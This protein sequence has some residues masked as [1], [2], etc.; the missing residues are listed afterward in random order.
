MGVFPGG[1]PPRARRVLARTLVPRP[2]LPVVPFRMGRALPLCSLAHII[3]LFP[4][5]SSC[6]AFVYQA[7]KK[8]SGG[9][10][11]GDGGNLD[12]LQEKLT[13]LQSDK[14]NEEKLRNYVQLERVSPRLPHAPANAMEA[15]P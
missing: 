11:G 10:E 13:N 7:K 5:P 12:E 6:R 9:G 15:R 2:P 1:T 8:S 3:A 14:V 4:L